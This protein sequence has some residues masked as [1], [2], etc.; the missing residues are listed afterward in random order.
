MISS[1]AGLE[2]NGP[3]GEDEEFMK[4]ERLKVLSSNIAGT[5]TKS[6]DSIEQCN[7]PPGRVDD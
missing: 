5:G 2:T 6:S 7:P 1:W 3:T 4:G